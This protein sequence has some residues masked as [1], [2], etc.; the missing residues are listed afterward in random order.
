ME[1]VLSVLIVFFAVVFA[2]PATTLEA[3]FRRADLEYVKE[4][5]PNGYSVDVVR[6]SRVTTVGVFAE[7]AEG[8][9][10]IN[11]ISVG[12]VRQPDVPEA[13]EALGF[14]FGLLGT[15]CMGRFDSRAL[16]EWMG[17]LDTRKSGRYRATFG[18]VRVEYVV[19]YYVG[20]LASGQIVIFRSDTPNTPAWPRFCVAA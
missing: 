3:L 8:R 18:T 16:S 12:F 14:A 13:L 2:Q 15:A 10:W 7:T 6:N 11:Q 1:R 9:R 19:Q 4:N 20:G 5:L 17:R